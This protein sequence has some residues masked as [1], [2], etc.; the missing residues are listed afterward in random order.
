MWDCITVVS[1]FPDTI[2][3]YPFDILPHV[4][5]KPVTL[6]SL[7]R[8]WPY[9]SYCFTIFHPLHTDGDPTELRLTARI[10]KTHTV[11][12]RPR[13]RVISKSGSVFSRRSGWYR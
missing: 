5:A 11:T 9:T 12:V 6:C 8:P 10:Y 2:P 4:A 1:D 7:L 3:I 13:C